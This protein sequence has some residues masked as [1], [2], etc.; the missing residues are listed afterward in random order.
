MLEHLSS[1]FVIRKV[2][3]KNIIKI[4]STIWKSEGLKEEQ[5]KQIISDK[6]ISQCFENLDKASE[7]NDESKINL[8]LKNITESLDKKY[9]QRIKKLEQSVNQLKNNASQKK[10]LH[11]Q[12]KIKLNLTHEK[13][14][15]VI[16][17]KKQD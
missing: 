15:E 14:K 16:I 5:I 13:E 9:L 12:E 17:S 1:N 6:H 11:E 4:L 8:E 10:K 7:A 3:T 2:T